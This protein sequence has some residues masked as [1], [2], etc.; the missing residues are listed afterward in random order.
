MSEETK[1]NYQDIQTI[2]NKYEIIDVY[3]ITMTSQNIDLIKNFEYNK[4]Y[5]NILIN[6]F[7]RNCPLNN[8]NLN[9]SD[10]L[11]ILGLYYQYVKD[12]EEQ[13]T[14]LFK[15]SIE[16][17]N[18]HAMYN[19]YIIN[20]YGNIYGIELQINNESS[21]LLQLLMEF[22]DVDI[23]DYN[24]DLSIENKIQYENIE[25]IIFDYIKND[26]EDIKL[27]KLYNFYSV[28]NVEKALEIAIKIYEKT[29][30]M[31]IN[32]VEKTYALDKFDEFIEYGKLCLEFQNDLKVLCKF[33]DYYYS[34]DDEDN[35]KIYYLKIMEH[36]ELSD[37]LFLD[38]INEM[39]E[40]FYNPEV[41]VHKHLRSIKLKNPIIQTRLHF[42]RKNNFINLSLKKELL[43]KTQ[44]I[45]YI[46]RQHYLLSKTEPKTPYII[47]DYEELSKNFIGIKIL[48]DLMEFVF[49][50]KRLKNICDIYNINMVDYMD[51]F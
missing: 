18:K 2:K 50:P 3:E 48:K 34:I 31:L 8:I 33:A 23:Y 51:M 43:N 36:N 14:L 7:N 46:S 49:N 35:A 22:Q 38:I 24:F 42:L 17:G 25:N 41:I 1:N 20:N 47:R 4:N 32:I 12:N 27:R 11:N 39:R 15:M 13:A 10:I 30:L 6:I 5:E 40:I 28:V 37:T 9:D 29:N 44:N 26:D 45:K 16:L 19:D 21:R